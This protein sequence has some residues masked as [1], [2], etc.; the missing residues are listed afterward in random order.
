MRCCTSSSRM[1]PSVIGGPGRV[2]S[3]TMGPQGNRKLRR[4][5]L[6]QNQIAIAHFP[7]EL[8]YLRPP[9]RGLREQVVNIADGFELLI[10]IK[11]INDHLIGKSRER[12]RITGQGQQRPCYHF[13][14]DLRQC[15]DPVRANSLR[16]FGVY[17]VA[18]PRIPF[19][20]KWPASARASETAA[21]NDP[22]SKLL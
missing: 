20:T 18:G 8:W 9:L 14:A 13:F 4:R 22:S 5:N 15:R 2:C 1:L 10:Q 3:S 19:K 21:A 6:H 7:S 17:G 12:Q 11:Q 16:S